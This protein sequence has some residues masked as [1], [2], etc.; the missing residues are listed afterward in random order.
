MTNQ[1]PIRAADNPPHAQCSFCGRRRN[2][3]GPMVEG[4]GDVYICR[5]CGDAV[6]NLYQRMD[7]DD[8]RHEP[9]TD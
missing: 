1:E 7:R 3:T 6:Q 4:P 8:L 9:A 5:Q 2:V